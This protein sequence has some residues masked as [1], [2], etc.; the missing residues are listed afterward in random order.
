[1]IPF[2]GTQ[3]QYINL[4]EE[5]LD[6]TDKVLSTGQT[7]DGENSQNF[8][9]AIAKLCHRKYAINVNSG[10][11]ALIFILN[12][13][14]LD[15]QIKVLIPSISFVA[16]LNS[17]LMT[18]NVP[19][20]CDVDYTGLIDLQSHELSLDIENINAVMYVNLFGNMVDYDKLYLITKFF[21]KNVTII[22]DA[23]QSFGAVYKDQPS[24]SLGDFSIL[25]FDPTKNLANY[26]SG[27]MILTDDY[28]SVKYFN[29]IRNNGK[30]GNHSSPGT[31]S[32]MSE[33]DCAQMLVKLKYFQ[34]WQTRRTRIAEYYNQE[35][36]SL[37]SFGLYTLPKTQD[38]IHSWHKY[39]IRCDQRDELQMF[40]SNKSIE[41]KIHYNTPLFELDIGWNFIDYAK[42]LYREASYFSGSCLSLPIYPEL[43]DAE[44]QHVVDSVKLYYRRRKN[45][46]T[47]T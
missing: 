24:G 5:I 34:D 8:D 12:W 6:V 31:N 33:V 22:E 2:F 23:A 13:L 25:S 10:T 45:L 17:V 29:D 32:K 46:K 21:N 47:S 43:S 27:G 35:L 37:K 20:F 30:Y 16:T 28:E 39:V 44:V 18:G 42:E 41:T 3:R 11:Q 9:H 15:Q 7:L 19:K 36:Y 38:S 4:R 26:G 1:M 40:L 14:S